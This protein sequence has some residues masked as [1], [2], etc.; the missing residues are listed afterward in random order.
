[1]TVTE[2]PVDGVFSLM[3][4]R[5]IAEANIALFCSPT[6]IRQPVVIN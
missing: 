6:F 3:L 2:P 1:M 5:Y 4:L